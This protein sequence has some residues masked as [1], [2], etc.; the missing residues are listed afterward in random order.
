MSICYG[1][2]IYTVYKYT[3]MMLSKFFLVVVKMYLKQ[4]QDGFR[5]KVIS[6]IIIEKEMDNNFCFIKT[7]IHSFSLINVNIYLAIYSS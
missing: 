6:V 1:I 3:Y 2:R 7:A 5:E 4:N